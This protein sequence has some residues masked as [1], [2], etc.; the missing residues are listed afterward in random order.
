MCWRVV[1]G[2]EWVFGLL[3]S[4]PTLGMGVLG[5]T[6][7]SP[8]LTLVNKTFSLSLARAGGPPLASTDSIALRETHI[9]RLRCGRTGHPCVTRKQGTLHTIPYCGYHL[10]N[11]TNQ[12]FNAQ[13][14]CSNVKQEKPHTPL[15]I[16]SRR[17][18]G[19]VRN[20]SSVTGTI[21]FD[22]HLPL[23]RDICCSDLVCSDDTNVSRRDIVDIHG[24]AH[25]MNE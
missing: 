7:Q 9:L 20:G 3:E 22:D 13:G 17:T 24:R 25:R 16:V 15:R 8:P 5:A 12:T 18:Q 11:C 2:S 1:R 19:L 4:P 10:S 6:W 21:R 14:R 23:W